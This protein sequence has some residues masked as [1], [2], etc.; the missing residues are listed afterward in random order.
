MKASRTNLVSSLALTLF[1]LAPFVN[2]SAQATFPDGPVKIVV[3]YLPGGTPDI[4][5]RLIAPK[6][7][8]KWGQPVIVENKA[9]ANGSIGSA[10]VAKARPDGRTMVLGTTATHVVNGEL[11]SKMA[12]DGL[13]DFAPVVML[14]TL[15]NVLIVHPD[16]PA[17]N[18][19]E[20][21]QLLK[22]EPGKLNYGSGG[23]GSSNHLAAEMFKSMAGVEMMHIPYKS[24]APARAA[25]IGGQVSM[26]F[27][28]VP[29][30]IPLV[31]NGQA[32]ALGVTSAKGAKVMPNVPTINATGLPGYDMSFWYGLLV[33]AATS[34]QTVK[35]IHNDV[36]QVIQ[37]P[38]ISSKFESLGIDSSMMSPM[39][40][41][42]YMNAEKPKWAKVV[43]DSG[44]KLD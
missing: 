26:I 30:A 33:P 3:P 25:L 21:I 11:Y 39:Q 8:E 14:G 17:K 15:S 42:D 28:N 41:K 29:T 38:E 9:G 43:K 6:L 40:F 44:A 37:S 1:S 10:D 31:Q 16:I 32:K 36:M 5:A 13:K 34:E 23:S 2:A 18:I 12:Y 19:A 7:T 20:L 4:M 35:K 22:K 24:S 27:E